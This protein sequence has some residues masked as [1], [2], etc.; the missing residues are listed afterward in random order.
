[1]EKMRIEQQPKEVHLSTRRGSYNGIEHSRTFVYVDL[2][3]DKDG[4]L[5]SWEEH[6]RRAQYEHRC[7]WL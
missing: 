4:N 2:F 7:N 6:N 1:M 5:L 3:R